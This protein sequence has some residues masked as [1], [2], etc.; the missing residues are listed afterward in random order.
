[1]ENLSQASTVETVTC[2]FCGLLCDDLRI[3]RDAAGNL[4]V[5]ENGC[6]KSVTF[7]GRPVVTPSPRIAGKPV[8][9][10]QAI[11]KA[12]EI[13]GAAKQPLFAGL[14]T[15]VY[16]MRAVMN[17]AETTNAIFRWCKTPAG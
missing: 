2:P 8:E 1:M 3:D 9:L 13:L 14:G 15:E 12:A 7:F 4:K 17:L 6:A 10:K 16:G 11:A 5:M